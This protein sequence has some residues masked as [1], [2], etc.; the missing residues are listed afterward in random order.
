MGICRV[1]SLIQYMGS[2]ILCFLS[3]QGYRGDKMAIAI[4]YEAREVAGS[5][6]KGTLDPELLRSAPTI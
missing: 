1:N 4:S 3:A 2:L 5:L 6:S